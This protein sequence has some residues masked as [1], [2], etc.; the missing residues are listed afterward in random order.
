M[1]IGVALSVAACLA[2]AVEAAFEVA[3]ERVGATLRRRTRQVAVVVTVL[4]LATMAAR[5]W[6]ALNPAA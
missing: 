6:S 5:F 3:G 1:I 2:L 4:A